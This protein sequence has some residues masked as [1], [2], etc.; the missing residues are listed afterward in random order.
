MHQL[1]W[2]NELLE[3]TGRDYYSNINGQMI[4]QLRFFYDSLQSSTKNFRVGGGQRMS[5]Q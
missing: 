4:E 5:N 1:Q 2:P 3:M